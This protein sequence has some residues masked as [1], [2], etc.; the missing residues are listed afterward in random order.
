M[1]KR[2]SQWEAAVE[3]RELNSVLCGDL[4][5]WDGEVRG[6]LK[7]EGIYVYI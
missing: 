3:H 5:E 1:C 2:D 6:R 7:R 4:D